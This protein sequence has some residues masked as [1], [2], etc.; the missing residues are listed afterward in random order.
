MAQLGRISGPLLEQNLAREG[1]DL[2]F[3]NT[4]FDS[5]SL[6]YLAVSD[7][8][9]GVKTDTP[10]FDLDINGDTKTTNLI[11]DNL[12]TVGNVKIASSGL[13]STVVGPLYLTPTGGGTIMHQ[14]MRSDDLDFNDNTISGLNSN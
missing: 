9:I 6:L 11:V 2:K 3:S 13:F 1:I 14:R 5:V 10:V 7:G 8:R 4:T 12:A